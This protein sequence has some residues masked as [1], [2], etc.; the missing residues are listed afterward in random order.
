[1]LPPRRAG[2]G[3][4]VVLVVEV[5]GPCGSPPY[6]VEWDDGS[7]TKIPQIGKVVIHGNETIAS[8]K[9][10]LDSKVSRHRD[11]LH[12]VGDLASKENDRDLA[13]GFDALGIRCITIHPLADIHRRVHP[14]GAG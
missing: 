8:S 2:E 9:L 1:M 3:E 12:H 11:F 10:V 5:L 13:Q 14:A 4:R 7:R 6:V